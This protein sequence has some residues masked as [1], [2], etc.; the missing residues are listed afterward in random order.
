MNISIFGN[1]FGTLFEN[2]RFNLYN[3]FQTN[4]F[5]YFTKMD[6]EEKQNMFDTES[7]K[8]F[9]YE[10]DIKDNVCSELDEYE[11]ESIDIVEYDTYDEYE[12]ENIEKKSYP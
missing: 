1:M 10:Y 8:I 3:Y 6:T 7:E 4:I 11:I 9:D 2:N 12:I 5:I